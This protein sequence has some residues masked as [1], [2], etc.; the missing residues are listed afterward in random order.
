MRDCN[1]LIRIMRIRYHA[2]LSKWPKRHKFRLPSQ[3]QPGPTMC[4]DLEDFFENLK[5]ELSEIP[6]KKVK[7]NYN[8][9][10]KRAWETLKKNTQII[11]KPYDKGRGIAVISKQHY[12]EEGY[13]QLSRN[14]QYLKLDYNPTKTTAD[15]LHSLA[16]EM[17]V[18]KQ[19]DIALTDYLDPFNGQMRTPVFFML[20]KVHKTPPPGVRFVG[21]PVVSNCSSPLE[22][23][24]ELIDFYLLP[25]VRSQPTYLKDI[26]DTI[27]KIENLT[28]P[29]GI[30]LASLDVVSM[31]TSVPQD[32]AFRVTLET[33]ANLD[34]F[35][36]DPI[37]PDM[38]YMAELL[39]LVLYRNSFEFND[40][41]FL[42]TS[43]VPMGQRS[44]GSICNLV[45]HELENKILQSTTHIHTLYRYMDDTLVFWTGSL[46][47]LQTFVQQVNTFHDTLKF[48]YE[49]SEDTIQ[50]LDLVIY[51]G[52]RF[53]EK[54]I[55]D[56]KCHTKKTETGQFLHR[57]LC[58]P[59]PVFDGFVRAEVMRYARNNNN[60]E[61]F[62][63]KKDFFMEKL[64]TRGYSEAEL[65]KAGSSINFEDRHLF[66]EEKP[67]SREIPLVFKTK[68]APHFAGKRI[69][70]AIQKHWNIISNNQKLKIIFP[71]PPMIAY[72]RAENLRDSLVKAKL[73]S[74]EEDDHTYEDF[75]RHEGTLPP[76]PPYSNFK[77]W[78][79]RVGVSTNL[80]A[81]ED[82]DTESTNIQ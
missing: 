52:K 54:G 73:P 17:Y 61:T 30:I 39:R 65:L 50:F 12:L 51:K 70:Q 60:Y 43:G 49:D 25:V 48:T 58:H 14:D 68:Y 22:R 53:K 35:D 18:E 20:P 26:G 33:L 24:S 59:Q 41:Y 29:Q 44:S 56:I 57:S 37:I 2:S 11:L 23:A 31:F 16:C 55:L 66:L 72:S 19:I 3:W 42:Q 45:V 4:N 47:D 80:V 69:K 74:P 28:L 64:S 13:R 6:T 7:P 81:I 79:Q 77:N 63:E 21:R 32:Q 75:M 1:D 78:K 38:K 46:E 62:L 9:N 67:K 71:K 5:V 8:P 82:S 34:P 40:E 15:M 76:H 36:Y 27:R 10:E